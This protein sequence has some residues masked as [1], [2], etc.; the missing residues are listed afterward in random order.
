MLK[1]IRPLIT[2]LQDTNVNRILNQRANAGTP[3]ERRSAFRFDA[4][5][6]QVLS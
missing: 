6:I 4:A 5:I 2:E 1:G 3:P